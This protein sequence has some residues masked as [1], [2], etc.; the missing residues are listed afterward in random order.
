VPPS[1]SLAAPHRETWLSRLTRLRER[2]EGTES[3]LKYLE[4]ERGVAE[5]EGADIMIV[6]YFPFRYLEDKSR[7]AKAI[8]RAVDRTCGGLAGVSTKYVRRGLPPEESTSFKLFRERK[9]TQRTNTLRAGQF[10]VRGGVPIAGKNLAAHWMGWV[11]LPSFVGPILKTQILNDPSG[12]GASVAAEIDSIMCANRFHID[13]PREVANA[14]EQRT[15]AIASPSFRLQRTLRA[16]AKDRQRARSDHELKAAISRAARVKLHSRWR[17]RIRCVRPFELP[18]CAALVKYQG[19]CDQSDS[20]F[21]VWEEIL[22]SES[23]AIFRLRGVLRAKQG[24]SPARTM[25]VSESPE[26]EEAKGIAS[27]ANA[28]G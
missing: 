24:D 17:T 21:T 19:N 5:S 22:A 13:G 12:F 11:A 14:V 28:N 6:V 25:G 10:M 26:A 9:P 8:Q 16:F 3:R 1:N 20:V 27:L 4:H 2:H 18:Q 15:A 23:E 7:L